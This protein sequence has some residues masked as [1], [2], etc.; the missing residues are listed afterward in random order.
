MGILGIT[1]G[2]IKGKILQK[3]RGNAEKTGRLEGYMV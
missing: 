2:G 3:K 1:G